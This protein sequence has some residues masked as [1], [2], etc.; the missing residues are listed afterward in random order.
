MDVEILLTNVYLDLPILSA[1][2]MNLKGRI[3]RLLGRRSHGHESIRAL[4]DVSIH[5]QQGDRIGLCGPNGAGKSTL[6]RVMAGIFRPNIGTMS[7]SGRVV[8]MIDQ[9]LGFDPNASGLANIYLRAAF[10]RQTREETS[11]KIGDIIEFS[12]LSDRIN[13]PLSSYSTGMRTRLG[14]AISTSIHADILLIDEGIGTAD[15]DFM[16]RAE[17]RLNSFYNRSGILVMASHNRELLSRFCTSLI[18][19]DRGRIVARET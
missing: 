4:N 6:L 11:R 18:H 13:H 16:S 15:A 8:P 19:L 3:A 14:F 5:L 2:D 9:G 7:V 10:L 12:G 1:L 17:S